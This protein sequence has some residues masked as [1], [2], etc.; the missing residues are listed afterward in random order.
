MKIFIA[1]HLG[2][3]GSAIAREV[4]ANTGHSWVG[5]SRKELDLRS[6]GEVFAFIQSHN[7]DAVIVAAAKV[8]GIYANDNFPVDFLSEN[9]Q[10]QTNL[11]DAA[12]AADVDKLVFLG[13]SCIYPKFA[14]QPI[15]EESL[16]T[17]ALEPT[18]EA[19]AV[20]K[21]AGIKLVQAYRKQYSRRWISLMP[22]NLYGPGDNYDPDNSHV[23]PG[24]ISKILQANDNGTS[25]VELWG[26]GSPMREFLHVED[27]ASAC[28]FA[29][30]HFDGEEPL[31]VGSGEEVS[32]RSLARIIAETI[33]YKGEIRWD[34]SKPDGAPRKLLDSSKLQEMGWKPQ[35]SLVMGLDETVKSLS[36][37]WTPR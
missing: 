8:G 18:N 7:P 1:G 33:G 5:A 22:T 31:N 34:H 32:I 26:T 2:M 37:A 14:S 23:I 35:R 21:I 20:A 6:R 27:L 25:S 9:L 11:M 24:I 16:L 13:S 10:I 29:L 28:V 36:P 3:V 15:V 4:D 30:E 17:G 19:Y 12:H